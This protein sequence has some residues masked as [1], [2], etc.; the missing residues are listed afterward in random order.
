[1]FSSC[2][3]ASENTCNR[4]LIVTSWMFAGNFPWSCFWHLPYGWL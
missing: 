4:A 1:M 2:S 3:V